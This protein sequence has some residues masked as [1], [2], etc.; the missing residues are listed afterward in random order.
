MTRGYVY[1]IRS[2]QTE[3][4]Y[5]GSTSQTLS[6]RMTDH[7]ADYKRYLAG[8]YH[9]VTSFHIMCFEDAYI[10]MC[11]VVEYD[12]KQELHAV[13]MSCIRENKCV[14]KVQPGR[15][16][17]QHYIDNRATLLK[18]QA[19]YDATHSEQI[20]KHK[21]E[22]HNC[23]CGGYFTNGHKSRHLDSPKHQAFVF[24]K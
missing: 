14:N 19:E 16:R 5:Y 2:H 20:K 3:Q 18:H 12:V 8:H 1:S 9:W 17:E 7:R 23:E 13:E 6:Q 10:E 24:K 11:R 21:K 4:V 22:K 15:T